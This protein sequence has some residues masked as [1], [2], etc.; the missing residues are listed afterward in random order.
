MKEG[1]FSLRKWNSNCQLFCERI[2]QIEECS[3]SAMEALLKE[4]DSAQILKQEDSPRTE[5]NE[6]QTEQ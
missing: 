5:N 4:N 6:S 1:G 3:Q 2:K